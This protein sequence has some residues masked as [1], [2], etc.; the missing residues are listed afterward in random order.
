LAKHAEGTFNVTSWDEN[1]YQQLE[2]DAKLT[3]ARIEQDFT[4]DIEARVTWETLMCYLQDGTAVYT[5]LARIE[6]RVG[7]RSGS[8]VM[9]TE[10]QFAGS[11]AKTKMSVV[12]G[13]GTGELTGLRG[14]GTSVAPHGS[15]GTYTLDYDLG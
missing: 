9:Q 2:G 3:K 13:S 11:E 14:E 8:F 15:T 7:D 6:G 12:E 10:G 4:G 5:G 1:T